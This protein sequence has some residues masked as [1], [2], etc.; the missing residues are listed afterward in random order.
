MI[1]K[2]WKQPTYPLTDNW[3]KLGYADLMEDYVDTK[4]MKWVDWGDNAEI[5]N[6]KVK[7]F[8]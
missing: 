3:V 1:A 2:M 5:M 4:K 6:E 7:D 8:L